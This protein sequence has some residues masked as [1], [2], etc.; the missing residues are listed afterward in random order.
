MSSK[1]VAIATLGCKVNQ[2]ESSS[3]AGI[4]RDRG[5]EVVDFGERADVYVINTCT[6]THAGD[7]KSRQFIRRAVRSNPEG[8]VVVAGCYAQVSPGEVLEIPGVDLVIGTA[9]KS[10]IVDRVEELQ[11]GKKVNAV[12]DSSQIGEYEELPAVAATGR[13]RA[14]LKIQEGCNNYCSYCIVPYARGPLRSRDPGRIVEEAGKLVEA[15]YREVVL[16]GIHTGAY[17]RDKPGTPGL[18]SLLE[19]LS[20]IKGLNRIRLSSVEPMDVHEDLIAV[21]ARGLPF[22]PHLHIPLQS[23]DDQIL[24]AMRRHYTAADF[25]SLAGGIKEKIRDVSITTDVIVGFPGETAENF[26]NTY[27]LAEEIK[28]SAMHVFKYSPR[29][30]TAAAE[31]PGQVAGEVKERRSKML[32]E[33]GSVLAGEF[34]SH[35][36]GREV[37]VLVEDLADGRP[38]M[39]QG[40][41]ANYLLVIFPG[42][43]RLKG[44]FVRVRAESVSGGTLQ[45]RKL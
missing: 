6:V 18:A 8:L 28:F 39:L 29:K 37:E 9:E 20:G 17:G 16:T 27:R 34:A 23:G 11:K 10:L 1:K 31:F 5:Y 45:G 3:I 42:E 44:Q 33:L 40:H 13:T 7:R 2:Y 43:E 22:C 36:I 26:M 30:G 19:R 12:L 32:I 14:F 21:M 15:G 4:F 25:I 38:G 35:Y 41:T 24:S